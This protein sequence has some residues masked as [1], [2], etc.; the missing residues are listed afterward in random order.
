MAIWISQ[1]HVVFPFVPL[2]EKGK[3]KEELNRLKNLKRREIEDKLRCIMEKSG[4]SR[5]PFTEE[6]LDEDFDPLQHDR[7]MSEMF[8]DEYEEG[9]AD[10]D[11]KKPKFE[12]DPDIDDAHGM[13]SD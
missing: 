13:S 6:E 5:M 1:S 12:Y 4:A 11:L 8:P 3:R 7:K 10:G 9:G 2:Q